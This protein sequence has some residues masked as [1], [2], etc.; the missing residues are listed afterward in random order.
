MRNCAVRKAC[1]RRRLGGNALRGA[2]GVCLWH[3][4]AGI[5]DSILWYPLFC[6]STVQRKG[7][8]K[9]ST[10]DRVKSGQR[11][12]SGPIV[13]P[14]E[15]TLVCVTDPPPARRTCEYQSSRFLSK[16]RLY[17]HTARDSV[18]R[19]CPPSRSCGA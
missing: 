12:M 8:L 1:T 9:I 2:L 5:Y 19:L 6:R 3:V 7:N 16:L 13:R 15:T 18:F 4:A 14:R 10:Q 17:A 11:V